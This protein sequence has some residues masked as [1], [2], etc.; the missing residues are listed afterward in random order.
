MNN[1]CFGDVCKSL[2]T[3]S[4]EKAAECVKSRVTDENIDG[5]KLF[6]RSQASPYEPESPSCP[7][8]DRHPEILSSANY[9]HVI[10][11]TKLPG[12]GMSV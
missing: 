9:A 5:C 8:A 10:G 6:L 1:R 2:D 4:P 12:V 3:Q 7:Q 11:L